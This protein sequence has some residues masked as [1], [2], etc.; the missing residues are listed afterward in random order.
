MKLQITQIPDEI[1]A[2]YNLKHKVHSDGF[3]YIEIQKGM[4]GLP[5]AGMLANKLLKCRL[6]QHRYYEVRH[7]PGYWRHTWRPIDFT[8]VVD[9]FGVG[10]EENEHA[11]HLLQTLCIYYEVISVDW[12]C[13]LYCD[14]T[15]KWDYQQRTC[16]LSMPGY[17]Q[18]AVDK[19][20]HGSKNTNKA[21][22][23]PH[24][25]KATTKQGLRM[26]QPSDDAA[27]LSPQ[28]IKHLQQNVGTFLFYSR[29]L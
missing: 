13:K 21:I 18:Q 10:Y 14:I 24:P 11:L 4:Y 23:A 22:D 3:V 7:T 28:V 15:L 5:Q 9:D 27:K 2:E 19:F 17:V 29:Q 20:Q 26:T 1:I 25:Y 6:A 8:L 12:K 16:K